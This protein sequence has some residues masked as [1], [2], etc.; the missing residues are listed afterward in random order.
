MES[1][2]VRGMVKSYGGPVPAVQEV[3]FSLPAGGF[4]V[5]LGPSGAGKTTVLGAIAGLVAPD[6]GEVLIGGQPVTGVRPERR[7]VAMVFENYA[8]YPHKTVRQ[9][10]EFPLRAPVR[11]RELTAAAIAERV[12][13][14][15]ETLRIDH[16]LDRV[17]AQLSGGQ[18]QRVSLGR[19]LVRRPR[20]L[21]LDEPITHLDA[22]L[23]HEMRTELK[24][25]QR[26]LRITTL[27]ATPDQA[28]ALA[29]GDVAV[30]LQE[31][32][33]W[34]VG[35]PAVLW[36]SPA[37]VRVAGMIGDPRMNLLPVPAGDRPAVA[38]LAL[39]EAPATAGHGLVVGIRP[40][41]VVLAERPGADTATGRVV[42][43]Q[44]LGRD[45]VVHVDLAGTT[46]RVVTPVGAGLTA[47]ATVHVR[48]PADRLHYF[49]GRTGLA[50]GRKAVPCPA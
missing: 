6:E 42:L 20:L 31:G 36:E 23:R 1:L 11:A 13:G 43:C 41:D 5:L 46:V 15:A 33:A 45:Q 39:P 48:L 16:L 4:G 50:L 25:I 18:R 28:D 17:P 34:Q 19:A 32:R 47:G 30:V 22:K 7:D 2:D 26:D 35:P 40:G 38:G 12:A 3:S 27:Y 10:L 24:R 21:L 44:Q 37:N 8:L 9:N 29:L 14:V 49:D